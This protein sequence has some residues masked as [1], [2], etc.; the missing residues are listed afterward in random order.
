M[1]FLFF[2]L[3][4]LMNYYKCN[5]SSFTIPT[6]IYDVTFNF[7]FFYYYIK[8]F[9]FLFYFSFLYIINYLFIIITIINVDK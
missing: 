9:F 8:D 4:S 5:Q 6:P 1:K 7:F 3:S 2:L